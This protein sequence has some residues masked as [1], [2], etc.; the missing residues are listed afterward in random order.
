[1]RSIERR[2]RTEM[3]TLAEIYLTVERCAGNHL[4]ASGYICNWCESTD[5]KACCLK[6]NVHSDMIYQNGRSRCDHQAEGKKNGRK[7]NMAM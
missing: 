6:E 7:T 5:P 3:A 4:I 1:M 2:D